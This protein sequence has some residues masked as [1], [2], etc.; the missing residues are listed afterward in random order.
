MASIRS[1]TRKP[2]KMFTEARM[3]PRKPKI[4]VAQVAPASRSAPTATSAPTTIT[5]EIAL[6]TDISGVC[7]AGVTDQTT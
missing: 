6:V 3:T 2:P 5:E 7:S 1:V 4:R